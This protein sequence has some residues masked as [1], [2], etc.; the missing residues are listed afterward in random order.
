MIMSRLKHATQHQHHEVEALMPVLDPAL[1]RA[2]YAQILRQLFGVIQPLEAHLLT[3]PIPAAL[4]LDLRLKAPL[5]TRDLKALAQD[6]ASSPET[7][8]PPLRGVPEALGA[9]YVLEGATLG[10]Q[11]ITRHLRWT[12]TVTP[13]WGGAYFHGYG[14]DTGQMWRAFGEAMNREVVPGDEPHVI[15]GARLAFQAFGDALRRVPA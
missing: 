9:L 5:L 13:E 1:S 7:A 10:G 15:A 3:L 8:A 6:I 4:E 14:P 12:L 11:V 2:A